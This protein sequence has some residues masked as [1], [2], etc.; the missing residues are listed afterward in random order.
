MRHVALRHRY[1][2]GEQW[3]KY[4]VMLVSSDGPIP[5]GYAHAGD[6]DE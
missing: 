3:A 1:Y 6:V 5:H 2:F 4:P